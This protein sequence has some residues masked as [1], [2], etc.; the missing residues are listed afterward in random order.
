MDVIKQLRKVPED[1]TESRS[2]DDSQDNTVAEHL[3]YKHQQSSQ[4]ITQSGVV[5]SPWSS[6]SSGMSELSML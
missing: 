4:H 1:A 5:S 2:Q 6:K 3:P